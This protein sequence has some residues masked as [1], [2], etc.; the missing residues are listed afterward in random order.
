MR[1]VEPR[2]DERDGVAVVAGADRLASLLARL[3]VDRRRLALVAL[4]GS[5]RL[6]QP[7]LADPLQRVALLVGREPR[8]VE[9][10]A[11]E[12]YRLVEAARGLRAVR[13]SEGDPE[14]HDR[15]DV[16]PPVQRQIGQLGARQV[17]GVLERVGRNLLPAQLLDRHLVLGRPVPRDGVECGPRLAADDAVDLQ[18]L[19]RLELLDR[20]LHLLVED[21]EVAVRRL[22]GR[23]VQLAPCE[24]HVVT[25]VTEL[26]LAVRRRLVGD[27]RLALHRSFD[28]A[29][30]RGV[31]GGTLL[32]E[33]R[34][35]GRA[36]SRRGRSRRA[37]SCGARLRLACQA[38]ATLPLR[39][40]PSIPPRGLR[41][42]AARAGLP[43]EAAI[44]APTSRRA[45]AAIAAASIP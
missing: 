16:A 8:Q 32:V 22:A 40:G 4:P 13:E 18:A 36:R 21:A 44:P 37:G 39:H 31:A 28:E 42:K 3:R 15:R 33:Q 12:S 23:G 9:V 35:V 24:Q 2:L 34:V 43:Y 17:A 5:R 7:A 25:T 41:L 14:A 29:R 45:A 20:R 6:L 26:Q 38:R 1:H 30:H 27:R 10:L 19:L 11:V